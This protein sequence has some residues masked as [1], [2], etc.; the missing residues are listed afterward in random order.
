MHT[1]IV[2][3]AFTIIISFSLQCHCGYSFKLSNFFPFSC[4]SSCSRKMYCN[5]NLTFF[6]VQL[7]KPGHLGEDFL[8]RTHNIFLK[9]KDSQVL[10]ASGPIKFKVQ[11][12]NR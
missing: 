1:N 11:P 5:I 2:K 3:I 4:I 9:T 7:L 8:S 12:F 10:F 6:L